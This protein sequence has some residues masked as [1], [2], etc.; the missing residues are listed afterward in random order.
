MVAFMGSWMIIIAY[1]VAGAMGY[2]LG[3]DA[4][5]RHEKTKRGIH[6]G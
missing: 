2:G 6:R 1:L 3:Y 4:G 5:I